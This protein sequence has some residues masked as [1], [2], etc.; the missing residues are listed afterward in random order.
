MHTLYVALTGD[1]LNIYSWYFGGIITVRYCKY[2]TL[3][4]LKNIYLKSKSVLVLF[5]IRRTILIVDIFATISTCEYLRWFHN[6][7]VDLKYY[8]DVAWKVIHPTQEGGDG[9]IK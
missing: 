6:V 3:T 9:E 8:I 4:W 7:Y 2:V 1:L 5:V